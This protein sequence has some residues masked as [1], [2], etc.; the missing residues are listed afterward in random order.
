MINLK[1]KFKNLNIKKCLIYIKIFFPYD[2][3]FYQIFSLLFS[4]SFFAFICALWY[5]SRTKWN[6]SK[7]DIKESPKL[8]QFGGRCPL[9]SRFSESRVIFW[10]RF[11]QSDLKYGFSGSIRNILLS[12]C[13]SYFFESWPSFIIIKSVIYFFTNII[14]M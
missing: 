5:G 6:E 12:Q 14:S 10:Q 3:Y 1:K 11:D 2:F 7:D 4:F 13:F 9:Y 8:I